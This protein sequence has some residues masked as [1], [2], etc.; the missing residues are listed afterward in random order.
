[1]NFVV[2]VLATGEGVD[3]DKPRLIPRFSV[4]LSAKSYIVDYRKLV[5]RY[6]IVETDKREDKGANADGTKLVLS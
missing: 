6:V 3:G 4:P 1:M 2:L 5:S